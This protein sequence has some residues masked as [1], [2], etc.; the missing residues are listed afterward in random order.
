MTMDIEGPSNP[1][2]AKRE[3]EQNHAT[4][5]SYCG[6]ESPFHPNMH[7][8]VTRHDQPL[9][10]AHKQQGRIHFGSSQVRSRNIRWNDKNVHA[11]PVL[12]HTKSPPPPNPHPRHKKREAPNESSHAAN[13]RNSDSASTWIRVCLRPFGRVKLSGSQ[14][15][16]PPTCPDHRESQAMVSPTQ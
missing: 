14:E 6:S 15:F 4:F 9:A 1:F 10:R 5:W 8:F 12:E 3:K 13:E 16:P 11:E 2:L 7:V